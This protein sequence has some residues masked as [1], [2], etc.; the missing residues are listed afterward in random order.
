MDW[1]GGGLQVP[2][3][4]LD[5]SNIDQTSPMP[6][7]IITLSIWWIAEHSFQ[8]CVLIGLAV[9]Q[10]PVS[11]LAQVIRGFVSTA[12]D[13]SAPASKFQVFIF[14]LLSKHFLG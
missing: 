9:R 11:G 5:R 4:P 13:T 3:K 2:T 6:V 8:V 10:V 14:H 7:D 1:G 12:G